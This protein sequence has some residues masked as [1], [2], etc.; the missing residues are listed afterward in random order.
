MTAFNL[1]GYEYLLENTSRI[2]S[3]LPDVSSL[4]SYLA[5]FQKEC[6]RR[7]KVFFYL[8]LL[9]NT[10]FLLDITNTKS[11]SPPGF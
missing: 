3:R 7:K 4:G 8:G 2:F 9:I 10:C 6:S 1:E 5:R 11:R